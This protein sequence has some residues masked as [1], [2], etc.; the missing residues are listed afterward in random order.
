MLHPPQ[1]Y[2]SP[3]ALLEP[4]RLWSCRCDSNFFHR[5]GLLR[6]CKFLALGA[7]A[8][9]SLQ[10]YCLGRAKSSRRRQRCPLHR[11]VRRSDR[12]GC[13]ARW[14]A[15]PGRESI[16]C[17]RMTSPSRHN[18]RLRRS[19]FLLPTFGPCAGR[20]PNTPA[21]SVPIQELAPRL[22]QQPPATAGVRLQNG[23]T[24]HGQLRDAGG[25]ESGL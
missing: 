7:G 6:C 21:I 25:L 4:S 1:C 22:S 5:P 2:G 23:Q 13:P 14:P 11:S 24:L 3:A 9:S 18:S 15:S 20:I 10:L 12:H 8:A 17:A 19:A 16:G